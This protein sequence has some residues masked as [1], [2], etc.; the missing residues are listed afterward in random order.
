MDELRV[1]R[2]G[3]RDRLIMKWMEIIKE[4]MWARNVDED[5]V[6]MGET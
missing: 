6:R 1:E 4:D 5:M 2:N 3:V